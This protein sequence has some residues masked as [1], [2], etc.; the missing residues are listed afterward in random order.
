MMNLSA[1]EESLA[2]SLVLARET[3]KQQCSATAQHEQNCPARLLL[4][5]C[6]R[7]ARFHDFSRGLTAQQQ[8]L[9][10]ISTLLSSLNRKHFHSA[11]H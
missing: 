8:A 9:M 10:L 7:V 5:D 1:I 2:G 3:N 11:Q 6:V 4:S